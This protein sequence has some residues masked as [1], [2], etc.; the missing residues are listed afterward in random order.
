M[1][2]AELPIHCAT[3]SAQ[4]Q[5]GQLCLE[6]FSVKP[7][8]RERNN[9]LSSSHRDV[10]RLHDFSKLMRGFSDKLG[11][12]FWRFICSP[13]R[14]VQVGTRRVKLNPSFACYLQCDVQGKKGKRGR[15]S[16][17]NILY[18]KCHYDSTTKSR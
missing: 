7:R 18:F 15:I 17:L 9:V 2:G 4:P 14:W 16:Y 12:E 6:K 11:S 3:F 10:G 13:R 1:P 8:K 5:P